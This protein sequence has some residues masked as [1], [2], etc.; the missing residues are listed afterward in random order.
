M[1]SV[2]LQCFK[3]ML[4][5]RMLYCPD[6]CVH[7]YSAYS[8]WIFTFGCSLISSAKRWERTAG[9]PIRHSR[10]SGPVRLPVEVLLLTLRIRCSGLYWKKQMLRVECSASCLYKCMQSG[11][12][13]ALTHNRRRSGR[14]EPFHDLWDHGWQE[15]GQKPTLASPNAHG[16][17][18]EGRAKGYSVPL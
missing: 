2:M 5:L 8:S 10:S 13:P 18:Q 15:Q 12:F 7:V 14:A 11:W 6:V 16:Q 4:K 1:S 3:S 17:D 9:P